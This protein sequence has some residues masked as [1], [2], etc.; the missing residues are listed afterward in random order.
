MLECLKPA[1]LDAPSGK[2]DEV[3]H[4]MS[5]SESS[6]EQGNE[7]DTNEEQEDAEEEGAADGGDSER[8]NGRDGDDEQDNERRGERRKTPLVT[9]TCWVKSGH[10]V[11]HERQPFMRALLHKVRTAAPCMLKPP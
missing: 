6:P 11:L 2:G 10:D 7:E 9:H 4:A 5:A 1:L 3:R 8:E